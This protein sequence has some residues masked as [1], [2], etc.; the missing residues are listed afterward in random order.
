MR[1]D[2]TNGG[3]I[4]Q[5][6]LI[7]HEEAQAEQQAEMETMSGMGEDGPNSP[8]ASTRGDTETLE[9]TFPAK[10]GELL[11]GCHEPGHYD[12]GIGANVTIEG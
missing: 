12:A 7:G 11:I 8:S 1:F 6:F 4:I 10:P 2:V 5:Y 9:F 3:Q